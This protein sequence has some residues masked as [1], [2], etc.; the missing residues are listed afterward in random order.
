MNYKPKKPTEKDVKANINLMSET[1]IG[2]MAKKNPYI[3]SLANKLDL[4]AQVGVNEYA[5]PEEITSVLTPY[6][7][8]KITQKE[9]IMGAKKAQGENLYLS[10]L[11]GKF[12]QYVKEATATSKPRK[13]T[14]G[15]IVNEE[16]YSEV[17]GKLTKIYVSTQK[18]KEKDIDFL[19]FYMQG[20]KDKTAVVISTPFKQSFS[21]DFLRRIKNVDL[22]KEFVLKCFTI[23][24]DKKSLEKG[25]DIYNDLLIPYQ[26]DKV[27]AFFSK[28]ETNGLPE[29]IVKKDKKGVVQSVDTIE[30]DEFLAEMIKDINATLNNDQHTEVEKLPESVTSEVINTSS[31]DDDLPF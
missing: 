18:I 21:Q 26:P 1:A 27:P 5:S 28:E 14:T 24:N 23:K 22:T 16:L 4:W 9:K 25:K 2:L 10:I 13:K 12:R 20:V 15:D 7:K 8:F 31:V 6:Q 11:K 3:A 19:V 17:S 30:R 29:I